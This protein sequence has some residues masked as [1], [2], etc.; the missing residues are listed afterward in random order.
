MALLRKYHYDINT[1]DPKL[2]NEAL[3]DLQQLYNICS[4]KV[5]DSST[6]TSPR[7]SPISTRRGRAT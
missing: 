4:I 6:P 2:I 1:E 7:A 3:N 5:G